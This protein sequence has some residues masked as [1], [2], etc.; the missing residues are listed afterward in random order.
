MLKLNCDST[1]LLLTALLSNLVLILLVFIE[2]RITHG[3]V[4]EWFFPNHRFIFSKTV[5]T[6]FI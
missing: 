6:N 2:I 3:N 1:T 5:L 4:L